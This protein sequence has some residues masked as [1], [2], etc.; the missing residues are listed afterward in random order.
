MCKPTSALFIFEDKANRSKFSRSIVDSYSE[1]RHNISESGTSCKCIKIWRSLHLTRFCRQMILFKWLQNMVWTS[2]KLQQMYILYYA[3]SAS[4]HL[5]VDLIFLYNVNAFYNWLSCEPG[6]GSV[7]H[8][9]YKIPQTI[10]FLKVPGTSPHSILAHLSCV[11]IYKF[12]QIEKCYYDIYQ[13]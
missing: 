6:S 1:R 3:Y 2:P 11:D 10:L 4:G 7:Y 5:N 8:A 9:T 13:L 12:L